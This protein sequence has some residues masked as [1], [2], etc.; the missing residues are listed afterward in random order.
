MA[1]AGF[2]FGHLKMPASGIG[3]GVGVLGIG[4]ATRIYLARGATDL[5]KGFAG[6]RAKIPRVETRFQL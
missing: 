5:R 2:R 6:N 4:P 3:E 1:E